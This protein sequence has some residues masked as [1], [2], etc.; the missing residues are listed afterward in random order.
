LD[1]YERFS[2]EIEIFGVS[3]LNTEEN[4]TDVYLIT[5]F[6]DVN[7]AQPVVSVKKILGTR[8][9]DILCNKDKGIL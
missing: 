2:D 8:V 5:V 3:V 1:Q 4:K 6:L 7:A 9:F